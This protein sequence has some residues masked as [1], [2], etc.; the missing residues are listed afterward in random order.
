MCLRPYVR[1][2]NDGSPL[3]VDKYFKCGQCY[4][5][6]VSRSQD[7]ATRLYFESLHH[8]YSLF[9]TLTYNE[10]NLPRDVD[11]DGIHGNLRVSDL[12]GFFN[13]LRYYY[14]HLRYFGAGE[15]G[16]LGNRAHYH[17]VVFI[18]Q[19]YSDFP[20][21]VR[22]CWPFGFCQ[23]K[24][25]TDL[26]NFRY[27]TDYLGKQLWSKLPKQY[28]PF[29]VMSRRP[30]IGSIDES[31]FYKFLDYDSNGIP[32]F[33]IGP[34]LRTI[35]KY[36]LLQFGLSPE[37]YFEEI[38]E[39]NPDEIFERLSRTNDFEAFHKAVHAEISEASNKERIYFKRLSKSGI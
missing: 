25:M 18:D 7:W 36:Y 2:V 12:Q 34:K 9:I 19:H 21:K 6:I 38:K 33:R 37:I 14:P 16:D 5:C 10:S 23:V 8:K 13:R 26:H 39:K 28:R 20:N 35:P 31:T 27:L 29:N 30:G 1:H 3:G 24:L 11:I 22:K 17:A 32:M 4:E 15:Y